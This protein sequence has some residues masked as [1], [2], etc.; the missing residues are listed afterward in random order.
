MAQPVGELQGWLT[1][2]NPTFIP[3]AEVGLSIRTRA[4]RWPK[5]RESVIHGLRRKDARSWTHWT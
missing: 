2:N 3:W 1:F 5:R 4:A